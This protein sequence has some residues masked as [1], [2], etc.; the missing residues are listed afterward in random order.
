MKQTNRLIVLAVMAALSVGLAGCAG[1]PP[2][3]FPTATAVPVPTATLMQTKIAATPAATV[4]FATV[5]PGATAEST[6]ES[7]PTTVPRG[8]MNITRE[9]YEA[10]L[11]KWQQAGITNYEM[12]TDYADINS[13]LSGEW[14]LVVKDGKIVEISRN[15]TKVY[16]GSD[17]DIPNP[18]AN[19]SSLAFLTV[20]A[21]FERIR[22]LLDDPRS[23]DLTI[24]GEKYEVAHIIE[25]DETLGYPKLLGAYPLH[26]TDYEKTIQ[27]KS[28]Q[29]LGTP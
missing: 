17:R 5:E 15:G 7:T 6:A 16:M 19:P 2:P 11:A 1:A 28:L 3:Q 9:Q 22:K 13:E 26:I 4:A 10:A 23:E 18:E 8:G 20:S 14:G 12:A 25:F 21:Q 24:D 29:D 27:V